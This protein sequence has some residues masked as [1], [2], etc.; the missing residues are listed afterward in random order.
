MFLV[1][2]RGGGH[3]EENGAIA[4]VDESLIR[5]YSHDVLRD[6][7]RARPRLTS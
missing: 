3:K 7:T 1:A 6:P 4:M 2:D 5:F